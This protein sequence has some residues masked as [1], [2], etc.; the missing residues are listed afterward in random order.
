M[1][2]VL[3]AASTGAPKALDNLFNK[4]PRVNAAFCIVMHMPA[5][6]NEAM[7][8]R[9]RAHTELA[10]ELAQ[11]GDLLHHGLV[12]LAP[13]ERHLQITDNGRI[14]LI[15]SPKV[16]FVRPSADVMM[17]SVNFRGTFIGIVM[18][19][20]GKDGAAGI[21]HLKKNLKATTIAQSRHT[22][23][24]SGMP[25]QAVATGY[26]DYTLSPQEMRDYIIDT[27]GVMG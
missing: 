16:N 17:E 26:I 9:L 13:S 19:G 14:E 27:F 5:I 18:T 6:I 25:D 23:A 4:M 3:I 11:S 10:V 21:C 1:N 12:L 2:L 24:I 22:C 20:M 8:D 7:R 15:I